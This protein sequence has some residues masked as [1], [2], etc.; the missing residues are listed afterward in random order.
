MSYNQPA[1]TIRETLETCADY[2][3]AFNKLS[4]DTLIAPGYLVVAGVKGDEG[5]IITRDRFGV[6][7]ITTLS[8]ERWYLVQTN[9]DHYTGDCPRRCQAARG[10]FEKLTR[11]NLTVDNMYSE[12]LDVSPNLNDLSIHTSIM[13]PSQGRFESKLVWGEHPFIFA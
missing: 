6:A 11:A 8:D 12:V 5:A 10:N 3:C 7:N 9:S 1:W 2:Q 4:T 13:I